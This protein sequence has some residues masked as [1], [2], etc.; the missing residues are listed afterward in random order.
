M[1]AINACD[2]PVRRSDAGPTDAG[3]EDAAAPIDAPSEDASV[4]DAGGPGGCNVRVSSNPTVD[5]S[6]LCDARLLLVSGDHYCTFQCSLPEECTPY[7]LDCIAE[8]GGVC[9]P[10]CTI[11]SDC[12]T[13][14]YRCDPVGLFCDTYPVAP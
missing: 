5:C 8:I 4:S 3:V 7:G 13:G 1:F 2:G 6:D 9:A 14:F 11:D 12:P 10:R